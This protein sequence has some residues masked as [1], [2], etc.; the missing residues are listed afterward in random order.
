MNGLLSANQLRKFRQEVDGV[1]CRIIP[2]HG[3]CQTS[4]SFLPS[5]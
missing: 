2:I 1:V 3:L 4:D 5:L